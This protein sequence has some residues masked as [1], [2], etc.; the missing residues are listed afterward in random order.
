[1]LVPEISLIDHL[2]GYIGW[3][4]LN[5]Y[6][7]GANKALL[8]FK[9]FSDLAEVVG[10]TDEELSPWSVDENKMFQQQDLCVLNGEKVSTVHFDSKTSDI[11]FLEKCPLTD[12]N[13]N[14]TGLI[15]YCRPCQKNEFFSLLRQFDD[16]LHLNTN[17]YTLN[18]NENKYGLSSRECE[19][20]FLL[21]RGKSAKEIG[22]LLSLS[23]RTIESYIENIKNKM[24]C[25]NKAEILVK[26]V[27]N[28]YH[29]YIP[30]RFRL[31]AIIKTL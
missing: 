14:V 29:N 11:F 25:K 23:K 7:L 10:Q 31:A 3:K 24:D 26:A 1:M 16:K 15:Y 27:L 6:Y 22:V 5:R 4:D 2:P 21:I 13:N 18:G 9:G 30:A 12:P 20:V 17:H 8:E 19:C 28:G